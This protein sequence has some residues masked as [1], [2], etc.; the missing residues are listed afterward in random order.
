M[1]DYKL[2]D[3]VDNITKE[4]ALSTACFH[5]HHRVVKLILNSNI[6][7]Y[8][9]NEYPLKIASIYNCYESIV[10]LIEYGAIFYDFKK[11]LLKRANLNRNTKLID[12]LQSLS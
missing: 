5:N 6:I 2:L 1:Y 3:V 8:K 9:D 11:K 10:L 7:T 4:W 12:Y